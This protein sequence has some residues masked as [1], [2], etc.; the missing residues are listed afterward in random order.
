MSSLE[1]VCVELLWRVGTGAPACG[2]HSRSRAGRVSKLEGR[3][4]PTVRGRLVA[5]L[6]VDSGMQLNA[7]K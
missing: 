4:M 6:A 5:I 1:S 7:V 2:G 3:G